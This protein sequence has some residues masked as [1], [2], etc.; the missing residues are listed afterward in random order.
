MQSLNKKHI[1]RIQLPLIY[2]HNYYTALSHISDKQILKVA[3]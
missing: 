1:T 3:R 2:L